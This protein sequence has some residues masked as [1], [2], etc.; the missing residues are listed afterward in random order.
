M[1]SNADS[2]SRAI[3]EAVPVP[4]I[5][6]GGLRAENVG[7]AIEAVR[8]FAL[9]VCTGVRTN[10]VLDEEKLADFMREVRAAPL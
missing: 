7:A 3:A 8:P 9:D 1:K 4:V 10:G 5:L 2:R 6:A